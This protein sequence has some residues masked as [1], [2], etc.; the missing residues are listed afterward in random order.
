MP[1]LRRA[2]EEA[3]EGGFLKSGGGRWDVGWRRPL[4]V[5]QAALRSICGRVGRRCYC[6]NPQC[7]RGSFTNLPAGLTPY[8]RYPWFHDR[9]AF[10]RAVHHLCIFHARQDVNIIRRIFG[11]PRTIVRGL[12]CY[13]GQVHLIL[14]D[15]H[16][17]QTPATLVFS[18]DSMKSSLSVLCSHSASS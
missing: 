10:P 5:A 11:S 1:V 4:G 8:S 7:A 13:L 3:S 18:D 6:R 14:R 12:P 17:S 9:Q 15:L 16:A 2:T